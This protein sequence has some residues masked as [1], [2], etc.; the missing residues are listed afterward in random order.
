VPRHSLFYDLNQS[1]AYITSSIKTIIIMDFNKLT[2]QASSFMNKQNNG[3]DQGS[4]DQN[5]NTNAGGMSNTNDMSNTGST[6]NMGGN[7]GSNTGMAGT[8][9]SSDEDYGDKG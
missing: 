9:T 8:N 3:S 6:G 5:M 7:M 2:Q 4:A 1:T